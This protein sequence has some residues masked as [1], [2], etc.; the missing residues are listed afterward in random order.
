MTTHLIR[1]G[2]G[3]RRA[4]DFF[5]RH[6]AG[7]L[8]NKLKVDENVTLCFTI[9][10]RLLITSLRLVFRPELSSGVVVSSILFF[11]GVRPA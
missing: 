7:V 2:A 6:T 4:A 5:F 3:R 9:A 10:I 11:Q 8:Y 1:D